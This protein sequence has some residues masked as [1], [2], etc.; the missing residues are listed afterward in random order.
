MI[1]TSVSNSR[2]SRHHFACGNMSLRHHVL[3]RANP[4]IIA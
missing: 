2:G 3:A 1:F 4:G